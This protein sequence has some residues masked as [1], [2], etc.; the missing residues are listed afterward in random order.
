MK[1][2]LV[3]TVF[4]GTVA[5]LGCD[6]Q[7]E[8]RAEKEFCARYGIV[9]KANSSIL[10]GPFDVVRVLSMT[11]VDAQIGGTGPV[12]QITLRGIRPFP[13]HPGT[14]IAENALHALCRGS[15][16]YVHTNA[17]MRHA[18]GSLSGVISY[19]TTQVCT[20][21]VQGSSELLYDALNWAVVQVNFLLAGNAA[22]DT[23][24]CGHAYYE[25]FVR[26]EALARENKRGYWK[27]H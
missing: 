21:V 14:T 25:T 18:D 11:K 7:G 17:V 22:V 3:V 16:F 27:D 4:V 8:S 1:I 15:D 12:V 9:S 10:E 2:T 5:I 24:D 13:G 19:P 20:G 6:R 26:A 23:N